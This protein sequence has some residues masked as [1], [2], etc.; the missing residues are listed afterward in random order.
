MITASRVLVFLLVTG[1]CSLVCSA[2]EKTPEEPVNPPPAESLPA[3]KTV[4]VTPAVEDSEISAR[5]TRILKA[6]EWF[7]DPLVEVDEGVAFLTGST[8][9]EKYR[10]WAGDLSRN[11]QDVVAVVN[12]IEIRQPDLFD[13]SASYG[14]V[15]SIM[16]KT[17]QSI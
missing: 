5:L 16:R 14:T 10:Q 17:V 6:T 13:L 8:N 11:T 12:R 7:E 15:K 1:V 2:Q 3:P 4:N 9:D